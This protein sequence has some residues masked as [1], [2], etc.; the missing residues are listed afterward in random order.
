MFEFDLSSKNN[1]FKKYKILKLIVFYF[2]LCDILSLQCKMQNQIR[3]EYN[4]AEE[5]FNCLGHELR[6]K[7]KAQK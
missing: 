3:A 2:E 4:L 1:L 5:I 7:I 6:L